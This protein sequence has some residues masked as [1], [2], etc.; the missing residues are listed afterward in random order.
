MTNARYK[1]KIDWWI[2]AIL[3]LSPLLPLLS[4]PK[5]PAVAAS[6]LSV[7]LI[8]GLLFPQSYETTETEL[9]L[10]TGLRRIR[11][12]YTAITAVRPTTDSRSALAMSLDRVLVEYQSGEQLIAPKDQTAFFDDLQHRAPQL[13]K[14]GQDLVISING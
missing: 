9:V 13:T 7:L 1:A 14:R 2:G 4:F 8:F 5:P 12:P 11:I 6:A 3:F 10:R